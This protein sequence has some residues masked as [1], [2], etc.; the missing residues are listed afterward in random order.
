MRV[1][2]CCGAIAYGGGAMRD[3]N[4]CE[5]RPLRGRCRSETGAPLPHA[6]QPHDGAR[7]VLPVGS[8]VGA[9]LETGAPDP[10]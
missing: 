9:G 5:F 6:L 4:G 1:G 7:P 2:D 3:E 8:A 10:H